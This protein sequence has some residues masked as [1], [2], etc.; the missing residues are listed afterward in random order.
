MVNFPVVIAAAV[1]QLP[2]SPSKDPLPEYL[3]PAEASALIERAKHANQRLAMLVMWR[4]G[5]RVS[6][7]LDLRVDDLRLDEI[8]ADG[9]PRPTLVV[10][11]GKG[12]KDRLV[13]VHPELR[14]AFKILLPHNARGHI[15]H[16]KRVTAY[17][18]VRHAARESAKA[19]ELSVERGERV[20]PHTLRHSAARHWLQ[21]GVPINAVSAWL[22]HSSVAATMRYL[23]LVPD[24]SGSMQFIP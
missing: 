12:S 10:L 14:S 11:G 18:W 9:S 2:R 1:E 4:A 22:G 24:A 15:W 6:E 20:S 7:T 8:G 17:R 21:A 23:R 19:G 16:E 5:L 13:P 3:S